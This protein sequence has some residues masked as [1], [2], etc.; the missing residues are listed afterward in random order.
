M[1]KIIFA[2]FFFL[3]LINI[4]NGQ[5]FKYAWIISPDIGK[6][7]ADTTLTNII[8]NINLYKDLEFVIVS[9][10]LTVHGKNDELQQIKS[11][12]DKLNIPYYVIP[13][14][15]DLSWSESAG[16][17]IDSIF[18]ET[19][20]LFKQFSTLQ[21]GLNNV[22]TWRNG[23]G[24]FSP[25]EMSWVS[26]TLKS[27]SGGNEIFLYSNFPFDSKTDNWFQ[28][29]NKLIHL[30]VTALFS[31]NGKPNSIT[32]N[33]VIPTI[34]GK[35]TFDSKYWYYNIIENQND[36]LFFF[37]VKNGIAK[38]WGAYGK[39]ILD[40]A[41]I[42]T[43]QFLNYSEYSETGLPKLK[44]NVIWQEDFNTTLLTDL[45]SNGS[46]IFITSENGD[47]YCYDISGKKLWVYGSKEIIVGRPVVSS[48][49]LA[50]A[51]LQG[52]L[53]SLNA[54]TGVLIQVIGIGE[55]LT[56]Q[57]VT[58]Q[59]EYNGSLTTGVIVG[60][61]KGSLYCYSMDTFEMIWENH[62]AKGLIR[63]LPLIKDHR[64]FYGS[65]DGFLYCIDDRT[66]VLYW[67]WNEGNDFYT[68]PVVCHPLSDGNE[69][70]IST[71]DKY[72]SKIDFLLGVTK[73]RKK[74]DSWESLGLSNDSKNLIVKSI[75]NNIYFV[76]A[77]DGNKVKT[78]NLK[79]DFDLN[80]SKPLEWNLNYL[81]SA[82]NGNVYLIDSHY[83]SR[84]LLF[85]GNCRLNSVINIKNNIFAVS[86]MDGKIICFELN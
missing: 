65:Q 38:Q 57:L 82:E 29:T 2:I 17:K 56:S 50:V 72:V 61:S 25:A 26:D 59:I 43:T 62:S 13:G 15:S 55:P 66:G 22:V 20:F 37:E 71:P 58:T 46:D 67:K 52:D 35:N 79:Y 40:I 31:A 10:N 73:W 1:K 86:N 6:T 84:P 60:T 27:F 4:L 53:I 74:F 36:S 24:H 64:L 51:T 39:Q 42:D 23:A 44:A 47:I 28:L 78:V 9:G 49:I 48:N 80:P 19:H 8:N 32:S 21:M 81:I 63:D 54:K 45:Y 14:E 85:L 18:G 33:S 75:S 11:I 7:D 41:K 69:V 34:T 76:S 30:K 16:E 70:Y 68:A 12:L 5:G 83:N 3:F 77:R